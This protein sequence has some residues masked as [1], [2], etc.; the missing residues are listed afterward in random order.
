MA[1]NEF[2][3]YIDRSLDGTNFTRVA[4]NSFNTTF[5]LDGSLLAGVTYY[6]RVISYNGAG[7]SGGHNTSAF[8]GNNPP[9]LALIPDFIA[10][11]LRPVFFTAVGT[12]SDLP[13]NQLSYALDP[14]APA[15]TAIHGTNGLFRWSPLRSDAATTNTIT[16]RVTDNGAPPL[17]ATR[18]FTVVVRDYI[19]I[20]MVSHDLETLARFCN[21]ASKPIWSLNS[22]PAHRSTI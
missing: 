13:A 17:S 10:D 1:T 19:E 7:E 6:Y 15:G 16:V 20:V 3:Y 5:Y 18:T 12:D 11:V 21:R 2:G 14:G 4:T 8:T 9:S 22:W